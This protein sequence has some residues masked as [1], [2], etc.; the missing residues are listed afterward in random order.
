MYKVKNKFD[1]YF[2]TDCLQQVNIN[3]KIINFMRNDTIIGNALKNGSYWEYWMLNYFKK[4][5]KPGTN[6][7]DLGANIGTSTLL[8]S[9]VLSENCKIYSFD[10]LYSNVLYKNVVDNNLT[11]K[12]EVYP[13]ALG[14]KEEK[15]VFE[16]I[17]MNSNLN[18]GAVSIKKKPL[19]V[20]SINL[21]DETDTKNNEITYKELQIVPLDIFNF[22]NVS[23]MKIDVE[24][25]EVEVLE[26]CIQLIQRCKPIILIESYNFYGLIYSEV[27]KKILELNYVIDI[28]PEGYNDWII[29]FN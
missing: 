12:I 29:R 15:V 24:H 19:S 17:D 18:F 10:P 23:L 16:N 13:Y 1:E 11:D 26:G 6:M 20:H 21:V 28:I 7:I 2:N 14:S 5:Y 9:E 3:N 8:M 27:F 25:M 4:Y 22:D